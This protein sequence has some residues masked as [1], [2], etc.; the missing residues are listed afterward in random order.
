MPGLQ[1]ILLACEGKFRLRYEIFENS[2][3]V[4]KLK[5]KVGEA[6]KTRPY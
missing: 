2:V 4:L 1:D 5:V 3:A 6:Y